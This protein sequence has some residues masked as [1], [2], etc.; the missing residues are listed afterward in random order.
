MKKVKN[1][2][3]KAVHSL[4]I[5]AHGLFGNTEMCVFLWRL[6]IDPLCCMAGAK[7]LEGL[8]LGASDLG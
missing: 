2:Y 3:K 7:N 4:V 5:W 1:E 8:G 6:S